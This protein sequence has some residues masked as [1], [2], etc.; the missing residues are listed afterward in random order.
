MQKKPMYG[1]A[2]VVTVILAGWFSG[3]AGPPDEAAGGAA[4]TPLPAPETVENLLATN[5]RKTD[6]L[7]PE[8]ERRTFHVPEGFEVQLFAAEPDIGKPM[9][10]AFDAR[11]RLW[12][13][14]SQEYPLPAGEGQGR[15]RI[16]ILEDTDRDG[17]ADKFTVFAEGL[18]IPIGVIPVAGGAI[19]YSIPYVYRFFDL[20]GD[21]RADQK[22]VLYG[23]FGFRDTHGMVSAL[24]RGFDGWVYACHGFKNIST[25]RGGDGSA[26]TLDSGNT[27]RFALDGSR[28]EQNTYGQVNPFGLTFD[29]LGNLYSAD[30]H[31][32]PVYQLQR[33]GLYPHFARSPTGIGFGPE[34]IDHPHGSTAIA[35][36]VY[37]SANQFPEAFQDNVLIGDVITNRLYRDRVTARGSTP[38]AEHESD[39]L[40]S[41]D[42]WFRPVDLELGPDGAV[43]V[44]DFYNRIIG[45]YEVHFQHPA[46]DRT[47]GRIWRV[48]YKDGVRQASRN[49]SRSNWGEASIGQLIAD[50]G[51]ANLK[52]RMLAADQLADR[53]QGAAVDPVRAMLQDKGTSAQQRVQ[54]L[55]ILH[56][57]GHLDTTQLAAAAG[58][59]N[60][61]IRVHAMRIL[62]QY[63][64]PFGD[65]ERELAHAGL[66]DSDPLVQR[67]AADALR[68]HPAGPSVRRLLELAT[69]IPA[70]DSHLGYVTALALRDQLR[71]KEV[72]KSVLEE[73]WTEA[74]LHSLQTA[75]V[76]VRSAPAA[77]FLLKRIRS[78][79]DGQDVEA[80]QIQH[81]ARHLAG[82]DFDGLVTWG[83]SRTWA[84]LENEHAVFRSLLR[85]A[86]GREDEAGTL[87]HPWGRSLAQQLMASSHEK[88]RGLGFGLAGSLQWTRVA[89]GLV[90]VFGS[91]EESVALRLAAAR[92]LIAIDEARYAPLLVRVAR[93]SARLP[94]LR[95]GILDV[96]LGGDPA[97]VREA[98]VELIPILPRKYQKAAAGRLA[99]TPEGARILLAA[100][101]KNQF[102]PTVLLS[103]SLA[104]H[105]PAGF[106]ELK[107]RYEKLTAGLEPEDDRRQATIDRLLESVDLETASPRSGWDLF[108]EHCARCHQIAGRGETIGPHLDGIAERGVPRLLED[109]AD[110]SRNVA[111]GFKT[112]L[113]RLKNGA[114]HMGFPARED[115]ERLLLVDDLE[116][117]SHILKSDI[118]TM[119]EIGESP[120]PSD[121]P[122]LLAPDQVNDLMGF[123]M[124]PEEG[125]E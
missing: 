31:T 118:E 101:E 53:W 95:N 98:L 18:N 50:L 106:P 81:V 97:A 109:L 112:R 105:L 70:E 89:P 123:L 4:G 68:A 21:D 27:F 48:V 9:N 23:Q 10:M 63:S 75:L 38:V 121:F 120:M 84:S 62:A 2:A 12:V 8:E 117:E 83:R 39:F 32:Q 92:A 107:E 22:V 52:V 77:H 111:E 79:A 42:P 103:S 54:G 28:V 30:S 1:F 43:Y 29:P 91:R 87:L 80:A 45:H 78:S 19:A 114:I 17:K 110:P 71:E 11:G 40:V 26:I 24:T 119:R 73:I 46:R 113:I 74:E 61:D 72:L 104:I 20:D 3:C 64:V 25:A 102:P 16:T 99:W 116:N 100:A 37:Y 59:P 51:H 57:L 34:M 36:I 125:M 65:A 5:I 7:T 69:T 35:G 122:D 6:P 13:T 41:D 14:Q 108:Q 115:D 90:R 124:A 94:L 44:A 58:N 76:G 49:A 93:E 67:Q 56:R 47:R 55:W 85:G 60:R 15:D 82:A 86:E 66:Q 33:G 96:L 88:R